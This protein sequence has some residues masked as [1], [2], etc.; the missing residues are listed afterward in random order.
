MWRNAWAIAVVLW[1]FC[2]NGHAAEPQW[3]EY[4]IGRSTVLS[5]QPVEEVLRLVDELSRFD[6]AARAILRIPEP[7]E[8]LSF[9]VLFS[10][11]SLPAHACSNPEAYSAHPGDPQMFQLYGDYNH[12]ARL[13]LFRDYIRNLMISDVQMRYPDWYRVGMAELLATT[14]FDKESVIVGKIPKALWRN[15][16]Y[17]L[18]MPLSDLVRTDAHDTLTAGGQKRFITKAW[19]FSHFLTL[20]PINGE[21]DFSESL[22][23]YLTLLSN[24]SADPFA[25]EQSFVEIVGRSRGNR[26][27]YLSGG[28]FSLMKLAIEQETPTYHSLPA[29]SGLLAERVKK[30]SDEACRN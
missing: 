1:Q 23:K 27:H 13:S 6:R 19:L 29:S 8:P 3:S 17:C 16:E 7:F 4:S 9:T 24:G 15:V 20:G 25:F 10:S 5:D 12:R 11:V 21:D 18:T 28:R 14:D 2:L 22:D 26:D 30:F